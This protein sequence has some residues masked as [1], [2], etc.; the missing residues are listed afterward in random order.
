MVSP[1]ERPRSTR[2]RIAGERTR[3]SGTPAAPST[4]GEQP[5]DQ[6]V[7]EAPAVEAPATEPTAAEPTAG[8][9]PASGS[10]AAETPVTEQRATV[11]LGKDE[12]TGARGADQATTPAAEAAEAA[13]AAPTPPAGRAVPLPWLRRFVG[14]DGSAGPPNWVLAVLAGLLVAALALDGFVVWREVSHRQQEEQAARAMHS[15]I[16]E[17]PSVAEEAAKSVLSYRYDTIDQDVA[18]ARRFLTDDYAP[19]YISSIRN[20]VAGPAAETRS[21][22]RAQV[23]ASGV[24]EASGRRA[25][26]LLFVN[27]TTTSATEAPKTALNRVVFTMVPRGGGWKVDEIQAF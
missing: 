1:R 10:P 25:D 14:R 9:A 13:E 3:P 26:V 12:A 11:P 7:V 15:A 18:Q 5:V 2:R 16:V 6:S 21:T 24:S 20:V 22:V 17:A 23:L 8:E 27:Q 19:A 4:P